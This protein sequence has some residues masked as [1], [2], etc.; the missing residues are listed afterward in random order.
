[1]KELILKNTLIDSAR[2]LLPLC[3]PLIVMY[4]VSAMISKET[5]DAYV[6]TN[7]I[8]RFAISC[9]WA[10]HGMLVLYLFNPVFGG[11]S[12][13]YSSGMFTSFFIIS[14]VVVLVC[15]RKIIQDNK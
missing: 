3:V 7:K 10:F 9:W 8:C 5:S 2:I 15:V 13:A 12:F 14:I 6:V 11:N 1:M 4:V